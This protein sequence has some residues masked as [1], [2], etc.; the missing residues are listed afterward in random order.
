MK[1]PMI[2]W[3][4]AVVPC[5]HAHPIHGDR[6]MR[7]TP[8]G[9]QVWE[10]LTAKVVEGSYSDIITIKTHQVDSQGKPVTL[11][12]SG[13]PVKFMQGHNIFGHNCPHELM[14]G[15]MGRLCDLVPEL[16]PTPFQR[17]LWRQGAFEITRVDITAMFGLGSQA[18]VN[19]WLRSAEFS[20]RTRHGRPAMKGNTLYWGKTSRRWALKAYSKAAEIKAH[21]S[22]RELPE[23][24]KSWT[25]DKLRVELVIRQMQLKEHGLHVA[26]NWSSGDNTASELY[27][28]YLAKLQMTDN[29]RVDDDKLKQELPPR[30]YGTYALWREGFDL[31]STMSR[32]TFYR[33]RSE[34]LA[35]G[36][37]ITN[38]V[39]PSEKTNV[40]PLI[41][42]VEAVPAQ[43][44]D[45]VEGTDL[46]WTPPRIAL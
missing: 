20:S 16:Q 46:L 6:I 5:D 31:M 3:V 35:Y 26:A 28:Q 43:V 30:L 39:P 44:P 17:S 14:A 22:R 38:K 21:P 18:A 15:L 7:V 10:T 36:V 11:Y 2:D 19:D 42:V 41:R 37:D 1:F 9:E 23:A 29:M 25:A 40:V 32:R 12:V 45:W 4:S 8:Q 13:N 24:L 33:H 27:S 34:L